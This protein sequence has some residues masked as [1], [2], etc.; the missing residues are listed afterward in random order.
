MKG[1]FHRSDDGGSVTVE[2]GEKT[3]HLPMPGTTATGKVVAID[4][5]TITILWHD[6]QRS[7]PREAIARL[8]VRRH[9]RHAGPILGL[10][11]GAGAGFLVGYGIGPDGW[12][13]VSGLMC[14]VPG[15][16][17]GG[18]VGSVGRSG[19]EVIAF[20]KVELA[21]APRPTGASAR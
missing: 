12:E 13:R 6:E 4:D 20:D 18:V 8:E 3:L 17:L 19:W 11:L 16:F 9:H 15:A 5:K 21:I 10:V 2:I 14:V 1:Y 7:I